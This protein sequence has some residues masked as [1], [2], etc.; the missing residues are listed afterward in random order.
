[1]VC[2]VPVVSVASEAVPCPSL[3]MHVAVCPWKALVMVEVVGSC[4]VTY[5]LHIHITHTYNTYILHTVVD[6]Y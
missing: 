2:I 3:H 5:I 6:T 4:A 1:M